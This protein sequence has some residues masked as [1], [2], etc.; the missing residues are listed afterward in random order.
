MAIL[1]FVAAL[2]LRRLWPAYLHVFV[3]QKLKRELLLQ[4]APQR[5]GEFSEAPAHVRAQMNPQ[6][7]AAAFAQHR[8]VAL[9]LRSLDDS[10]SVLLPRNR[11]V[12]RIVGGDLQ[13]HA[14]VGST[15]VRLAGRMQE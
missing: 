15:F 10:E 2:S 13:K 1:R 11:H 6:G 7:P 12:V 9:S 5:C 4:R 14:S 3:V 8:E